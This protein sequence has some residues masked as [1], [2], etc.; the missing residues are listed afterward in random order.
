MFYLG[1]DVCFGEGGI[2]TR[3]IYFPIHMYNKDKPDKSHVYLFIIS[4]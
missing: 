2:A 1:L 4:D 3:F